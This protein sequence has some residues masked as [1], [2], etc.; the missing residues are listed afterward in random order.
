MCELEEV[1]RRQPR[2]AR[3]QLQS[4]E[5]LGEDASLFSKDAYRAMQAVH[6]IAGFPRVHPGF[7]GSAPEILRKDQNGVRKK[8]SVTARYRPSE[9]NVK[10]L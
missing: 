4:G 1:H 5:N 10:H 8:S 9:R 3:K 6:A 2:V 7:G